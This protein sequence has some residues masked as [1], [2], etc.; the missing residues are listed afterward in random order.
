MRV[1]RYS[2]IS[3][4]LAFATLGSSTRAGAAPGDLDTGFGRNGTFSLDTGC[5]LSE[6]DLVAVRMARDAQGNL[7]LSDYCIAPV[8]NTNGNRAVEVIKLDANGNLVANFGTNGVVTIDTSGYD[9]AHDIAVDNLGSVYVVGT[10]LLFPNNQP[11][12]SMTVWKLDSTSG[13]PVTS[14]GAAGFENISVG[15]QTYGRTLLLDGHGYLYVAGEA[16]PTS[17]CLFAVAKLDTNGNRVAAFNNGGSLL[18][19]TGTSDTYAAGINTLALDGA[20]HLYLAGE[21]NDTPD[22]TYDFAVADVDATSGALVTAFADSGVKVFDL[23]NNNDDL[24]NA[25]VLD[26]SGNLYLAGGTSFTISAN[27]GLFMA[28]VVKMNAASGA[29][30]PAFGSGGIKTYDITG[31]GSS[32]AAIAFDG[33]GHLYFAGS[34]Y[35]ASSLTSSFFVTK[36]D[37]NGNP[38]ADFG[39]NGSTIVAINGVDGATTIVLDGNGHAYLAGGSFIDNGTSVTQRPYLAA[40]VFTANGVTT[41]TLTSSLNPAKAGQTVTFTATVSSSA[42]TPTGKVTFNDGGTVVCANA[43]LASGHASCSTATLAAGTSTH[44]I[45]A[46][47]SGDAG[48]LGSISSVLQQSVLGDEVFKSGFE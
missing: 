4:L 36:V 6:S 22:R 34:Q 47:Y 17:A 15:N 28:A 32:A 38:T 9:E 13:A 1:L 45:S 21:S 37:S 35:D 12:Y 42:G 27:E 46:S 26:G 44:A 39:T 24:L 18:V 3:A 5:T 30:L 11:T 33:T 19:S 43:T 25:M 23:G 10:S 14:F 48:N 7:Y 16:C 20:G 31:D 41:T 40:R 2:L 8:G 29:L